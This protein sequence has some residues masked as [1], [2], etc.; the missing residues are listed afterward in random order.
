MKTV[1]V[2]CEY[3]PF[4]L[5]HAFQLA[6]IRRQ[7]GED[8]A[9]IAIMSGSFTQRGEPAI[10]GKDARARMAVEAGAS[11]VL[12]LP[13]PY[14]AAGAEFFASGAVSIANALGIVDVLS[15]G[16]ESG[17]LDALSLCAH[18]LASPEFEAAALQKA[19]EKGSALG[20]GA[21]TPSVYGALYGEEEASLFASPNN[22]LAL[23][24]LKA[25]QKTGSPILPHTILRK[26]DYHDDKGSSSGYA[27][28]SYLRALIS[29]GNIEEALL[30]MPSCIHSAVKEAWEN[31]NGAWHMEAFGSLLIGHFRLYPDPF[32]SFA[33]AEGGLYR[34]IAKA[35][36]TATDYPSL[37]ALATTKKYPA[38]R[39]R[40][41]A[42][43]SLLG[44]SPAALRRPV[45]Y[46]QA[47]A[48]D[49]KGQALLGQ[50]RKSAA[51]PVLTKPAAY[52]EYAAIR[53]AAELS[54]RADALYTAL[55]ATPQ[56]ADYFMKTAP[57]RK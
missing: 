50:I 14:S 41:A 10:F 1:A 19:K 37:I 57:Y 43:F 52:K 32:A 49:E 39:V 20:T 25:L 48:M 51:I 17:N 13:F 15:F 22:L 47:L 23:A 35:A 24:Y 56:A 36:R 31:G 34:R 8:A 18:R 45:A 5:G 11:L 44:V 12:E 4:H 6:E 42:L 46:T 38:A 29:R 40:R 21:L 55:T 9:I 2:I 26:G 3:N 27:S 54:Q 53:E 16:S 28:A 30:H 33:E 7:F